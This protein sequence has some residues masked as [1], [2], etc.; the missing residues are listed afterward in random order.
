MLCCLSLWGFAKEPKYTNVNIS[1]VVS[2]YDGDTFV[3]DID[4]YP[5]LVG[6]SIR[7]RIKGINTP[8]IK[9]TDPE[10]QKQAIIER[11]RLKDLLANATIIELRNVERCKYFRILSNIYIDG[12]N[13]LP[14]L[15]SKYHLKKKVPQIRKKQFTQNI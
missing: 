12:E 7:I 15:N 8:E 14:H 3:C 13:I 9:S 11:D 4:D 1:R 5:A 2:V 6:K 10:M